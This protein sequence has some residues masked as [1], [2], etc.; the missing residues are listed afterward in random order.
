MFSRMAAVRLFFF[1]YA[2]FFNMSSPVSPLLFPL[3]SLQY[4]FGVLHGHI[5]RTDSAMV[6]DEWLDANTPAWRETMLSMIAQIF[7]T[8]VNDRPTEEIKEIPN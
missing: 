1:F 2:Q 7:P 5:K 8:F 4:L 6:V 3:R